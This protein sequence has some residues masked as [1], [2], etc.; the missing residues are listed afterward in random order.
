MW[1]KGG[2][3]NKFISN[4]GQCK[5]AYKEGCDY[6]WGDYIEGWLYVYFKQLYN[7]CNISIIKYLNLLFLYSNYVSK[8]WIFATTKMAVQVEGNVGKVETKVL[9]EMITHKYFWS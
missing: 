8:Y 1:L 3:F 2:F 7:I 9:G 5:C 6:M 4:L